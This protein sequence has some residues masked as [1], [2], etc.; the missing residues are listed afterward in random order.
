MGIRLDAIVVNG[1]Y[2]ER[3][4]A[5]DARKLGSLD[6]R[7]SPGVAAAMKAALYEYRW[8]REQRQQLRRLRR[9]VDAPVM[10]LP[11]LFEPELRQPQV[12]GLSQILEAKKL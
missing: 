7:A 1:L 6:G 8:A 10:T 3:F 5:D 11:Y 2:P 12:E 4:S 9:G